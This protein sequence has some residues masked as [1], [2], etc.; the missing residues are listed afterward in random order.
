MDFLKKLISLFGSP[1][2]GPKIATR[3]RTGALATKSYSDS[4]LKNTKDLTTIV[5]A[6]HFDGA[7]TFDLQ[8][9]AG[10]SYKLGIEGSFRLYKNMFKDNPF[11]QDKA[12][13]QDERDRK[14]HLGAKYSLTFEKNNPAEFRW[15]GLKLGMYLF[16]IIKT[17]QE[18]WEV[19]CRRK[20]LSESELKVFDVFL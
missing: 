6:P 14:R 15:T 17:S 10:A 3:T 12:Q 1:V 16:R 7:N 9:A 19:N 18:E 13:R 20:L 11:A 8:K 4:L 5:V 2:S